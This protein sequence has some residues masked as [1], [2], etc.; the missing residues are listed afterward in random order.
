M[1]AGSSDHDQ[2]DAARQKV[3]AG[4]K[5]LAAEALDPVALHG[6]PDLSADDQA[7]TRR[8]VRRRSSCDEKRE[9]R[10]THAAPDALR[11]RELGALCQPSISS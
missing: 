5:A 10:G 11:T 2:I 3:G 6:A 4:A 1:C 9:V 7:E 8:P